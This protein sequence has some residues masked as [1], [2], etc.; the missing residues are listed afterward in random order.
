MK[1]LVLNGSPKGNTSTTLQT[2]LYLEKIYSKFEFSFLNVGQEI[3]LL[4]RNFDKAKKALEQADIILFCYPVYTFIIPYQLHRFIEL[5]KENNINLENKIASQIS[6]SKHFYDV[7]AH[8]FIEE[9][10]F[11]LKM[12]VVRGLSADMDDL[13]TKKG[14]EEAQMFFEQ[15][16]FCLENEN[17]LIPYQANSQKYTY[18]ACLEAK[19]KTDDF[20]IA[21]VTNC[22]KDDDTLKAMIL[23]F[24]AA[25]TCRS[26]IINIRDFDFYGGCLGCFSCAVTGKC[27]HKD[28]F[29][30]YLRNEIQNNDCIVYAFS[31][32]NHYTHSSMKNYDDRQFCNGHR[33]VTAGKPIAYLINGNYSKEANLRTIIEARSE[34]GQNFLVQVATSEKDTACQIS[35]LAK[36][37]VKA[38]KEKQ[39]RPQ[40]FYGVGGT[41]IFRDLIYLMQGMMK[42]DHKFYK[43][44]GI[45]DFPQY[46]YKKIW[47]MKMVG[48]LISI[49]SVQKKLK[50][51]MSQYIIGPYQKVIEEAEK[52]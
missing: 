18:E 49:P 45:Y 13:L 33:T 21:I 7:T 32:E 41:K 26:K 25:L 17:Y 23:D 34:V 2:A 8:K 22:A 4:E 14:Q 9:N 28:G 29:D 5:I 48:L 16:I 50:G 42:A 44:H 15:L 24:Q 38:L 20:E 35:N 39:R 51:Q 52:K 40:N 6:T 1:V 10:C 36:Y 27:I 37:L 19:E 11:D 30:N 46:Q 47:Q 31:I 3:K 43:K 12:K